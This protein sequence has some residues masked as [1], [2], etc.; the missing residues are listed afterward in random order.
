MFFKE[1]NLVVVRKSPYLCAVSHP[2]SHQ[3]S[4]LR[5]SRLFLDHAKDQLHKAIS[6]ISG[7]D[8]TIKISW[9]ALPR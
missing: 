8:S 9:D 5:V 2:A 6:V 7:A 3:N 1:K 4:A